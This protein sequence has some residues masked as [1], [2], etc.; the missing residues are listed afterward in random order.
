MSLCMRLGRGLG[1][2]KAA[3]A[4]LPEGRAIFRACHARRQSFNAPRVIQF[5]MVVSWFGVRGDD[6]RG[7]RGWPLRATGSGPIIRTSHDASGLPG[8][9]RSS[10]GS[11]AEGTLTRLSYATDASSTSAP[12][13]DASV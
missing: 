1:E 5:E 2:E 3:P 6:A 8:S 13:A 9:T 12:C 4:A 11:S 10:V 7:I